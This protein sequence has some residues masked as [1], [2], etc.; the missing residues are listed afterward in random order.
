MIRPHKIK[1]SCGEIIILPMFSIV[2]DGE[3]C[4]KCKKHITVSRENIIERI[5]E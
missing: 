5:D 2:G 4:P 3:E 1:C